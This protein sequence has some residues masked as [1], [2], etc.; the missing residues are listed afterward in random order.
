MSPF[1]SGSIWLDCDTGH[2]DALAIL[3][4]ARSPEVRLL[5]ISTVYGNA[6]LE[7]TTR[8]T[9]AVLQAIGRTDVPVYAGASGPL[10]REACFA[11]GI[12]GQTGLD[13]TTCLP[14]PDSSAKTDVSAVEGM[15]RSLIAQPAG[16]A[17]L[18]A[19]GTLTNV[20][21]LFQLHPELA[22][23]IAGLS[24]MGGCV[25]G[26][27]TDASLGTIQTEHGVE[28]RC[29]NWSRW[30][31]FSKS[32]PLQIVQCRFI[33]ISSCNFS[34]RYS[35]DALRYAD[36]SARSWNS[37]HRHLCRHLLRSRSSL[38]CLCQSCPLSQDH[39]HPT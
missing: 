33:N 22:G 34:S 7:K 17:W 18:V 5:G 27:F 39:T 16:T 3:I 29:G 19:V 35:D 21:L 24:I 12:H 10:E 6:P 23:H 20:A 11:P 25:G 1:E 36:L 37:D 4:A 9:L 26:G 38:L 13:G 2:D 28:E 32:I 8:N 14:E 15:Y 30:A 31:E